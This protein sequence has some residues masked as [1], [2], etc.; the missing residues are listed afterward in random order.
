MDTQNTPVH[1]R[2][3]NRHFWRLAIANLFLAMSAYMLI[4]TIPSMMQEHGYSQMQIGIIMLCFCM[5][6]LVFGGFSGYLVQKFRRNKV[7]ILSILGMGCITGLL[8]YLY[9]LKSSPSDFYILLGL[10]TL[11]GAF[12]GMAQMV[13]LST[14]VID[15]VEAEYRTEA[16][17]S[18]TWFG[19]FALAIGPLVALFVNGKFNEGM[20]FL[21]SCG[22]AIASMLLVQ[23]VNFPFRAPEDSVKVYSADRFILKQ[24]SWLSLVLILSAIQIGL[25]LGTVGNM[26]FYALFFVGLVVAVLSERFAFVDADLRSEAVVGLLSIGIALLLLLTRTQHIIYYIVPI[27]L[28]FGIGVIASRFLLFFIKLS[29]HCQ[30]G[31]SQSTYILSWEIGLGIGIFLE[32]SVFN[33]D[34]KLILQFGLGLVIATFLLYRFYV[35][36]WYVKHKNR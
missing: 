28:G 26:Q 27:L 24:G 30:R 6:I 15:T 32:Y 11:Q 31:T 14:L 9:T 35:H 4:P 10:R 13:M 36:G 5:G 17:Y 2:L 7:C 16:N 12:Y 29:K 19:R 23:S 21:V 8:Y 3:W 22:C 20:V 34:I 18:V 33:Q 25:I 1:I